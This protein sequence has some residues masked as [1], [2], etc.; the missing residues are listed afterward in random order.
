MGGLGKKGGLRLGM[1]GK[2]RGDLGAMGGLG[3]R[4]GYKGKIQA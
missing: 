4:D 2:V 1:G 3:Q